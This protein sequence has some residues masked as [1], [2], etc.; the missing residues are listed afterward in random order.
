M[1]AAIAA[2]TDKKQGEPKQVVAKK[3]EEKPSRPS[4]LSL[5]SKFSQFVGV[6]NYI[7]MFNYV[8]YIIITRSCL[9]LLST[10]R[11]QIMLLDDSVLVQYIIMCTK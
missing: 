2:Q 11:F 6:F 4:P 7:Y 10:V 9:I 5:L 3:K 8:L 1:R